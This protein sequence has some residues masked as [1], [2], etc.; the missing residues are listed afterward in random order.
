[1]LPQEDISAPRLDSDDVA[2]KTVQRL[3]LAEVLRRRRVGRSP[4]AIAD[5]ARELDRRS[6]RRLAPLGDGGDRVASGGGGLGERVEEDGAGVRKGV[7]P[8]RSEVDG[9]G[10]LEAA[11]DGGADL[12]GEGCEGFR[13]E[14]GGEGGGEGSE[15]RRVERGAEGELEVAEVEGLAGAV[16]VGGEELPFR[17]KVSAAE[18]GAKS[19]EPSSK[20]REPP[21]SCERR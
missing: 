8:A 4:E 2:H 19:G 9:G 1:M 18:V 11:P 3:R 14:E 10:V 12:G 13:G 7:V 17:T 5:L 6:R 15:D 21:S 20:R 16:E